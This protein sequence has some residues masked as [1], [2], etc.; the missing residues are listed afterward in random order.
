MA[1]GLYNS[2]AI[3][4]AGLTAGVMKGAITGLTGIAGGIIGGKGRRQE[5]RAAM[6][7][8]NR[9][10]ARFENLDTSNLA[11]NME[12]QFEDL[13]VNQQAANF[14]REQQQ[15]N[16]SN[17]MSNMG[18][19][20]GGSGIAAMAQALAGQ[21]NVA[22]QQTAA[23]LGAQESAN[24]VKAAQGAAAVDQAELAGAET[25]RGLERQKV[26]T[27]LGMS[28]QRVAAANQARQAA[29]QS[30]MGGVGSLLGAGADHI[31][32]NQAV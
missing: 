10:K 4:Q 27:L 24:Q 32:Q 28:Q 15:Q 9:N 21:G 13:T 18:G 11:A 26:S 29:T 17:I 30:I 1:Q 22:A 2:S 5:Q 20:A 16:M 23:G 3:K 31:E 25:A 19:A 6:A 12:N 14:E 8:M 7:E